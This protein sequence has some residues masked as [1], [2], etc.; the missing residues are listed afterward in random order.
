ME[1]LAE[2]ANL[3]GAVLARVEDASGERFP[4]P[5]T[6]QPV[7][8]MHPSHAYH[9]AQR[10]LLRLQ[11]S[12]AL[13]FTGNLTA[14]AGS[15]DPD[16]FAIEARRA[17]RERLGM[18][19]RFAGVLANLS[20]AIAST[21]ELQAPMFVLPVDDLDLNPAS[22]VPLLELLR[23]VHSPHLFVILMADPDLVAT[24]L[25]LKYQGDFVRLAATANLT[26]RELDPLADLAANALHKHFPRAQ[27]VVLGLVEPARALTFSPA[28]GG[29]SLGTLI[30][31]AEL[32]ADVLELGPGPSSL[33]YDRIDG[34]TCQLTL[35][36]S[37]TG[38]A[39]PGTAQDTATTPTNL[40]IGYSWPEVL[41]MPSGNS[42]ICT[43]TSGD[44]PRSL[45]PAS[46][47]CRASPR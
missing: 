39:R 10:D 11:T 44:A 8:L 24:I 13:G 34:P 16:T 25:R 2:S 20:A 31:C 45:L 36:G 38:P 18:N 42:W 3:L 15:L 28:S 14:R 30:G 22:C 21:S 47:L 12:A 41:R 37:K 27:R 35:A 46:P 23:A 26:V 9:D 32:A 7:S 17:E 19:R 40:T 29:L 6:G 33:P 5:S 1:A 4:A 43:W